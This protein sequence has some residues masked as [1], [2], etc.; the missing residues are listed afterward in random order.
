MS[1]PRPA[2]LRAIVVGLALAASVAAEAATAP[3]PAVGAWA[4][5]RWTSTLTQTMP[6]L[7]QQTGA[8]GQVSWSVVQESVAPGPLI[9][10]YAIVRGDRRTYTL[11]IVTHATP[12]APPLSVTQITVDR[13][14]GK[15][16]QSVIRGSKGPVATPESAPRPFREADVAQGRRE[17]VAVPAGR[18]TALHGTA[19]DGE[20]WVSA[21][22]PVLALVKAVWRDGTLELVGS[23]QSG[24]KDLL[25]AGSR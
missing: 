20:V 6:V 5:Y 21:E 7:V 19:Q 12:D 11:Q 15:T 18:F 4:S 24:V 3:G 17:D 2:P 8:S 1:R 9:V 13:A 16:R 10:T 23:G 14:S 25:K 22:V